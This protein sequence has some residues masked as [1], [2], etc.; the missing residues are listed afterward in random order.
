MDK[1]HKELKKLRRQKLAKLVQDK[2]KELGLTQIQFCDY[3]A[4]NFGFEEFTYG[5]LQSWENPGEKSYGLPNCDHFVALAKLFGTTMD[6]LYNYLSSDLLQLIPQ[7]D[8]VIEA[9]RIKRQLA[10]LPFNIKLEIWDQLQTEALKR[11]LEVTDRETQEEKIEKPLDAWDILEN[12]AGT[13]D[14]PSD[15]ASEHD[16]YLYGTPKRNINNE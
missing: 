12:M 14:A 8:D 4:K 15:W 3:I 16:H 11:L 13:I 7:K 10:Q 9:A 1:S 6:E 2:R 5:A